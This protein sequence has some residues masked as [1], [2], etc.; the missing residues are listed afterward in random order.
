MGV[1]VHYIEGHSDRCGPDITLRL[2]DLMAGLGHLPGFV[3]ADL[4]CSPDQP[5]L[6]L[7]ESRWQGDVPPLEVP[8]GCRAWAFTVTESWTPPPQA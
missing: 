5:G 4:L 8:V 7:L 3:G 2:S 1:Q 6:C